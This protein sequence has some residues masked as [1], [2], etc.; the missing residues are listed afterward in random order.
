MK[1]TRAA[2]ELL[3]KCHH[4]R[5]PPPQQRYTNA[6]SD[7]AHPAVPTALEPH[8]HAAATCHQA[9]LSSRQLIPKRNTCINPPPKHTFRPPTSVR[10]ATH[11]DSSMHGLAVPQPPLNESAPSLRLLPPASHRPPADRNDTGAAAVHVGGVLPP[12]AAGVRHGAD[13][14]IFGGEDGRCGELYTQH[15]VPPSQ[16]HV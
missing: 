11:R 6:V 5:I 10:A 12:A 15:H 3:P 2:D 9:H 16:R 8:V 1:S 7:L 14:D 4:M 13:D